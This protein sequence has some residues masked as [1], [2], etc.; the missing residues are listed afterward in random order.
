MFKHVS[1]FKF[2]LFLGD[3]I[4]SALIIYPLCN[5]GYYLMFAV[6]CPLTFYIFD[7]YSFENYQR[8]R[9]LIKY[10][11]TFGSA[12]ALNVILM[13]FL[14]PSYVHKILSLKL[15]ASL[16]ISVYIWHIFY[17]KSFRKFL[18]PK[19]AIVVNCEDESEKFIEKFKNGFIKTSEIE[20]IG[21]LDSQYEREDFV[22]VDNQ[23]INKSLNHVNLLVIGHVQKM[24][25]NLLNEVLKHLSK[26]VEVIDLISLYEKYEYKLPLNL[27]DE[28]YI[29]YLDLFSF[30]K[31]LYF[32]RLKRIIDVILAIV[33]LI[34]S[35]PMWIIICLGIKISSPGP[36]LFKQERVGHNGKIFK[37]IKFRTMYNSLSRG[38]YYTTD[39]DQRVFPFGKILRKFRIDELPQVINVIKGEMSFIGPRPEMVELAR[40]Y[41]QHIPF[42]NLRHLVKPGI[43]GWAQVNYK[44]GDSVEDAKKKL[45]YDL[46]Y[47]KNLSPLLDLHI[48]LRTIRVVL[49]AIGSR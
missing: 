3:I 47:I 4:I 46:F 23:D 22:P 26:G 29:L 21:I 7:L 14:F 12:F 30:K 10:F 13:L 19:K 17:F 15:P 49:F 33:I 35:F 37:I 16:F 27:I 42:Y 24:R 20:F 18:K 31:K 25:K 11:Y 5:L 6:V 36:V 32:L 48:L 28:F 8:I 39:N 40:I 38:G 41:E 9:Y 1:K 43:T 2:F 45:E 34:I 44:Y